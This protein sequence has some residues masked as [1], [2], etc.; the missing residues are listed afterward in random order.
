M[1]FT[2]LTDDEFK[3][4]AKKSI[5]SNFM[6]SLERRKLREKMGY[7]TYIIGL[8]KAGKVVAAAL[9]IE[10]NQEALIQIGP[11]LNWDNAQ[12]IK[13]FL[14][15]VIDFCKAQHISELE[16]YPPVLLSVRDQDGAKIETK[17]QKIVFDIFRQC[18]FSH[19]GF[20]TKLDFKALRWMFIKNL[21]GLKTPRD[22]ELSFNSSTRKKLHQARRNLDIHVV[23]KKSELSEWILPL[24]AS[25]TKNHINTRSLKYFED[26]WDAFSENATFVE[27]RLKSTGEIVSSELDIWTPTES[28]AFLAGTIDSL[29][30]YNGITAI[31]GW[32]L[33]ECLKRG[34]TRA[35]FYG[36]DGVFSE[37]NVLLKSK[38]GFGGVVEE[39]IGGFKII[40]N[41]KRYFLGKI[42]RKL[43]A[44]L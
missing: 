13:T 7:H 4:Y 10:K 33:E 35:N 25:D 12:I 6:Q 8:K 17:D 37:S 31:K 2:K 22:I 9:M 24:R 19:M 34:Q 5:Y 18:G 27:A 30:K 14:S 41:R 36:V 15:G 39:Y 11:L 16:I 23:E 32:Q 28:V 40:L 44:K 3:D 43:K 20:S 26:L 38:K 42:K 29:K 21:D 1:E